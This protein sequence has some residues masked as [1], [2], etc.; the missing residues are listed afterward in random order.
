[1]AHRD[2]LGA[3]VEGEGAAGETDVPAGLSLSR[4]RW[5]SSGAGVGVGQHADQSDR[6]HG[7]GRKPVCG[8]ASG[9]VGRPGLSTD[10]RGSEGHVARQSQEITLLLMALV[11]AGAGIWQTR[12]RAEGTTLPEKGFR[13][14]AP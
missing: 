4:D 13:R 2:G 8:G 1:M 9:D 12:T 6:F 14:H 11:V 3:S 5:R 7:S 10:T